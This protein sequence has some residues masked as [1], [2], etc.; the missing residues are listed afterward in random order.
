MHSI[1]KVIISSTLFKIEDL[2]TLIGIIGCAMF[3]AFTSFGQDKIHFVE[4]ELDS[5][6]KLAKA[7]DKLVFVDC[8]T[9]W[10]GPCKYMDA[11]IFTN[12]A[13]AKFYNENFINVKLDME[14]GE[15]E[16]FAGWY[17]VRSYPT[18][19]FLDVSSRRR[20]LVHRT[21]GS[22]D[23]DKFIQF[24]KD[25]S[26]TSVRIGEARKRY[27]QGD[28]DPDFIRKYIEQLYDAGYS[29]DANE[30][31]YWLYNKDMNWSELDAADAN[32]LLRFIN[33]NAHPMYEGMIANL[34]SIEKVSDGD[35]LY[36]SLMNGFM[37]TVWVG[38]RAE[39]PSVNFNKV[40]SQIEGLNYSRKNKMIAQI[41]LFYYEQADKEKYLQK[42]PELAEMYFQDD[43][44]TLNS[45]AW[46]IY[47]STTDKKALTRALN[48]V[49]RSVELDADYNNLDTKMR[50]L[51]VLGKKK[52]ALNVGNKISELIAN[53]E[54]LSNKKE[55]HDAVVDAMKK[56]KDIS[57]L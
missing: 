36:G 15:G 7:E 14:A 41:E 52:D 1:R 21:V 24:G 40:V 48:L 42:A 11:N 57:D 47:E 39:D 35:M 19:I 34:N 2:K 22:M 51:Y 55:G 12:E 25:A 13:V 49:N 46:T 31:A 20:E 44:I 56:G 16:I 5:A 27:A 4:V 23:A 43:W 53:S 28:R 8:Y 33:G 6:Y 50:L 17:E 32:I 10:C 9:T 30:I 45:V 18:Y 37:T 3:S 38:L 54:G 29:S 26:D